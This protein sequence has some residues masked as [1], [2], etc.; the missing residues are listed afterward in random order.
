MKRTRHR[1]C[2]SVWFPGLQKQP[3]FI[4]EQ[5]V[6][7][8]STDLTNGKLA[9]N[10]RTGFTCHASRRGQSKRIFKKAGKF[11]SSWSEQ[12]LIAAVEYLFPFQGTV[13]V[14]IHSF[15]FALTLRRTILSTKPG[16]Q[17]STILLSNLHYCICQDELAVLLMSLLIHWL[18]GLQW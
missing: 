2:S 13:F 8:H 4:T 6:E 10:F 1:A 9:G 3:S 17:W 16:N 11:S 15:H 5:P 7:S 18:H 14:F 12:R